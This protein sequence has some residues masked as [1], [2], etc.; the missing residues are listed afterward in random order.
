[1]PTLPATPDAAFRVAPGPVAPASRTTAYG[2]VL[3][4][5]SGSPLAAI[6]VKLYPWK[7]C[8]VVSRQQLDCPKALRSTQTADD[9]KF[10]LTNVPNGH[11]LLVIGSD[12][13][14]DFTRP[15]IHDSVQIRGGSQK[16]VAPTLPKVPKYEGIHGYKP[17]AVEVSGKYRLVTMN[18]YETKCLGELD[19]W[20]AQ[21]RLL[22]EVEDE[23]LSENTRALMH[24][25]L[26]AQVGKK[27]T[28]AAQVF[29]EGGKSAIDCT[30]SFVFAFNAHPKEIANPQQ[31]WFGGNGTAFK[32]KVGP[33]PQYFSLLEL[34]WDPRTGKTFGF[35][36]WP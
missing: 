29:S 12:S 10:T 25:Y 2:Y 13:T 8:K 20:R 33:S 22:S 32:P 30:G 16:L 18:P 21:H 11:Y 7:S 24:N 23:W 14:S 4:D 6:A 15:T 28:L 9:G 19:T 3:D 26:W 34:P 31:V 1:M 36:P 27:S 35:N 5:P 17:P